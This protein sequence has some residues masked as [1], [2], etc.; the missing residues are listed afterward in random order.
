MSLFSFFKRLLPATE[1]T[2][3]DAVLFEEQELSELEEVAEEN[4]TFKS[5]NVISDKLE[6]LEQYIKIFSLTCP[7]EYE[8]YHYAIKK[9]KEDYAVEL[10]NFEKGKEGII[11]FA[12]DPEFESERYVEVL[13]LEEEIRK[14]V[15]FEVEYK[16]C[17]EKFAKLCY[18][19]NLFYNQTINTD[20]EKDLIVNQLYNAYNS[21]EMLVKDLNER[22]FFSRDSR[23]KDDILNYIIYSDYII[24]KS[25]LRAGIIGDLSEYKQELSKIHLSFDDKHYDN[26]TFKF[27]MES[28]EEIQKVISSNMQV[29]SMFEIVLKE[30]QCLER[31]LDD[32]EE[33]FNEYEFFQNVLKLE[34]SVYSL[35]KSHNI[36]FSLD[37]SYIVNF[38]DFEKEIIS[39]NKIA[40]SILTLVRNQKALLLKKII[41]K[42]SIEI[43]WREFYF[44]CKIFDLTADVIK[45]SQNTVFSM[46]QNKFEK[47]YEKYSEYTDEYV[48][49]E[50]LRILNYSGTK[51][52]KYI[53]LFDEEKEAMGD[54]QKLL[55]ALSLDYVVQ[56]DKIY[57]N[58][59]YFNGF[60]NLEVNF[61]Q[62]IIF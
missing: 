23:K 50:K 5:E 60:K 6:Y 47:I 39:I 2:Q 53:L 43:S 45:K 9:L 55:S 56:E 16:V 35:I 44:L 33:S 54:T 51:T 21:L 42:F 25:F 34:N 15:D 19:L 24:F 3:E 22:E 18:K 7:E 28:I 59:S 36:N 11:T 30:S 32:Y 29:D 40:M 37:I 26:L 27:F 41:N 49:E 17:K 52:K 1:Q 31:K 58:H 12:I 62:E 14:F 57:L 8:K 38:I 46:V 61:G 20:I 4:L 13:A 48:L 10:A